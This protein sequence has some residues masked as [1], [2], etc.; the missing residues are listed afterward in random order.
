MWTGRPPHGGCWQSPGYRHRDTIEKTA[1][2]PRR[3]NRLRHQS[4]PVFAD[5][6]TTGAA[7]DLGSELDVKKPGPLA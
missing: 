1:F 4:L 3:R 5:D 6:D 7:G 2:D